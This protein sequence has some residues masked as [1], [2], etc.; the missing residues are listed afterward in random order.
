MKKVMIAAMAAMVMANGAMASEVSK[1]K[2]VEEAVKA[3]P[4][5]KESLT[6]STTVGGAWW[7]KWG[8]RWRRNDFYLH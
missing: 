6:F 7:N 3:A 8:E 1:D 4:G 2:A 5:V